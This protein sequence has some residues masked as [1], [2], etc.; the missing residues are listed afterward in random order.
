MPKRYLNFQQLSEK[1]G[2]RSR[3]S[4]YRDIA[5]KRL[6]EPLKIG[7]RSY[8]DDAEIEAYIHQQGEAV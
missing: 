1:L 2:G 4:I 8:W 5:A 6:P 7:R 3:T